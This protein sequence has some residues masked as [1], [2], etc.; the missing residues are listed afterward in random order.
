MKRKTKIIHQRTGEVFEIED[1]ETIP[2]G[3]GIRAG[4]LHLM[5]G[6][7]DVQR[8]IARAGGHYPVTDAFSGHRPGYRYAPTGN[9]EQRVQDA[10]AQMV[11]R[12]TQAWV[13]SPTA[14]SDNVDPAWPGAFE[15]RP[16]SGKPD[17][18]TLPNDDSPREKYKRWLS[19]QWMTGAAQGDKPARSAWGEGGWKDK[20]P[21]RPPPDRTLDARDAAANSHAE[22]VQRLENAWK[23]PGA[24]R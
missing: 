3:F 10:H 24:P 11:A 17:D 13:S 2:S 21:S 15:P 9:S 19:R 7:D 8:E 16:A 12:A 20:N 14:I 22:M 4:S 5:D 6:A 1:G 18:V 23:T